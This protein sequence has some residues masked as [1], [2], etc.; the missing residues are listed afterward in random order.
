MRYASELAGATSGKPARRVI[1]AATQMQDLLGAHRTPSS[2]RS[3]C[4]RLGMRSTG[5]ASPS[6]PGSSRSA[7]RVTR[8]AIHDR[9]RAA[10]KDLRKL[11]GK[12]PG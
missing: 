4:G 3:T 12:L 7:R 11:A 8:G 1:E 6:S 5:R 9:F 10:W 2:P